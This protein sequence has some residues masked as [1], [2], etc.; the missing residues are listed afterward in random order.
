MAIIKI[1]LSFCPRKGI[2]YLLILICTS[3][4]NFLILPD[5][6][7]SV[8]KQVILCAMIKMYRLQTDRRM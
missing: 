2:Y 5:D 1:F 8:L 4:F 3:L 7:G 6:A